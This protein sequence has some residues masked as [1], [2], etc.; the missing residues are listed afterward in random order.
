MNPIPLTPQEA[1]AIRPGEPLTMATVVLVFTVV[2]LTI[3]AFKLLTSDKASIVSPD[4]YKFSWD[5]A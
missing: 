3:V 4:G 2:I 5:A 1:E